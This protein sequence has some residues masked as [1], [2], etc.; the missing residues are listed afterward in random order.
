MSAAGRTD[1][2]WRWLAASGSGTRG[3]PAES[4][5]AGAA[6]TDS[7]DSPHY[8]HHSRH[9]RGR[10]QR[11]SGSGSGTWN[12]TAAAAAR[13]RQAAAPGGSAANQRGACTSSLISGMMM[14]MAPKKVMTAIWAIITTTVTRT[15][16]PRSGIALRPETG[17]RAGQNVLICDAFSF[18]HIFKNYI[19]MKVVGFHCRLSFSELLRWATATEAHQFEGRGRTPTGTPSA[20]GVEGGGLQRGGS[21]LIHR[22]FRPITVTFTPPPTVTRSPLTDLTDRPHTGVSSTNAESAGPTLYLN[23]PAA[24][25]V[26]LSLWPQMSLTFRL[27]VLCGCPAVGQCRTLLSATLPVLVDVVLVFRMYSA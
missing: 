5:L 11:G 2:R 15:R 12:L 9:R 19:Q 25:T 3:S 26:P 10:L 14:D 24:D 4:W 17:R 13:Q 27:P 23:S 21:R 7:K 6:A 16:L 18:A 20:A 22:T 8:R 1:C